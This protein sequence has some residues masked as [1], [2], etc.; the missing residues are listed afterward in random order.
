MRF[1]LPAPDA[2]T[3]PFWDALREHRLLF[4]RCRACGLA[5]FYPRPFCKHCWSDDVEWEQASGRGTIYTYSVVHH[6]D[7][8]PFPERVPYVAAMVQLEEGPRVTTNIV[9]CPVTDLQCDL[10][11]EVA[12]VEAA[13]DVTIAVFRP[14]STVR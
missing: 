12:F 8:P 2:S 3:Q 1:D 13:D 9:D 10:P 6:N 5:F 11:V 4:S 7:L 14:A